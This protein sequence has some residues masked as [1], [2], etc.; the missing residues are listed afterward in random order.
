M[1]ETLGF[2]AER[3][4][5]PAALRI[6]KTFHFSSATQE[7]IQMSYRSQTASIGNSRGDAFRLAKFA[8]AA[9]ASAG[10]LGCGG[11]D[12][13]SFAS[14]C[15]GLVDQTIGGAKINSAQVQA[16]D[17]T[18][19][20]QCV[21]QATVAPELDIEMRMP[22]N[23]SRRLVQSGG[24]GFDGTIP[25]LV[26]GFREQLAQGDAVVGSN[27]GHRTING[28]NGERL[29]GN[30][31]FRNLWDRTSVGLTV[32]VA[33]AILPHV[34]SSS[35]R[36]TYFSGC[37]NGGREAGVAAAYY[38]GEYDGVV[39]AHAPIEKTGIATS[40]WVRL[41]QWLA[42]SP[43]NV[44]TAGKS[45]TLDKA[46][47]AKCDGADGLVDGIISK[48]EACT[49]DA[50][51]LRCAP[52][53]DN[54]SCLT[55]AQITSVSYLTSDFKVSDGSIGYS[56][57]YWGNSAGLVPSATGSFFNGS[58]LGFNFVKFLIKK[59]LNADPLAYDIND[60]VNAQAATDSLDP[61]LQQIA[62]FLT[63]GK[64][65]IFSYGT[66]DQ[67]QSPADGLR[68]YL[69]MKAQAG[70]A[71]EANS[72]F[73]R[74]PGVNHCGGGPGADSVDLLSPL[75][76]WVESGVKPDGQITAAKLNADKSVKFTRPVCAF[77]SYP[78]YK[79]VGD[80]QS[81]SSFECVVD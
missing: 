3:R 81:A 45:A 31:G 28:L 27:G 62:G 56:G 19:P 11:S 40:H 49:F 66:A 54:D 38:G 25:N 42:A 7:E 9:I 15:T 71:G 36:Y 5:C 79:G 57:Y 10:L 51:A 53:V 59:D 77:S 4:S 26:D 61:G 1:L 8:L 29:V 16:G 50:T 74:L 41:G 58:V 64:K 44:L 52:G 43:Q 14:A 37:S 55:D 2:L 46:V 73:F 12:D 22:A 35:P 72:R 30:P 6:A 47:M 63:S 24:G 78:K 69:A 76:K 32:S 60:Y 80:A 68:N 48:P 70:A 23:W 65:A 39:A 75:M 67:L 13:A 34:Y 18:T 17:A 21:V 33:K 20:E